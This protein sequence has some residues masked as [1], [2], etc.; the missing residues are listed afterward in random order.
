MSDQVE[1]TG[2]ERRSRRDVVRLGAAG[3]VGVL[4]AGAIAPDGAS[5][6]DGDPLLLGDSANACTSRTGWDSSDSAY[7][8]SMTNSGDGACLEVTG[9]KFGPGLEA[10]GTG[11]NEAIS[12]FSPGPGATIF[13]SVGNATGSSQAGGI[14][15]QGAS[16]DSI[17]AGLLG[18][19][20]GTGTG[21]HGTSNGGNGVYAEDKSSAA[22]ANGLLATSSAGTAV[23]ASTN[24]GIAVSAEAG[25]AGG[26]ALWVSGPAAYSN[27]GV[28][29]VGG[30]VATPRQS[31]LV[32][33]VK[34]SANSLVVATLQASIAGVFVAS[35]VPHPTAGTITITLN[36]AVSQ[37]VK[38]GWIAIDLIPIGPA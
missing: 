18:E 11:S 24:T 31:V 22:T 29:T 30:S 14:A 17:G 19:N 7:T 10:F 3:V 21:V 26:T 33:G 16:A 13:A 23:N 32:K 37:H 2:D 8:L 5:A 1:M 36:Q 38:I 9:G 15:M 20:T 27:C 4:A 25:S 34:L 35:A 28:A 12:A 6:N